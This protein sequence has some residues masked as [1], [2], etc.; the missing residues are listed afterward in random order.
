MEALLRTYFLAFMEKCFSTLEPG[1]AYQDNWHLAAMSEALRRVYSGQTKRLLINVPPRSGKSIVTT[2]AFTAWLLGHDPRRRIICVSYSEALAKSHAA[3]FRTIV[4][5]PWYRAL[6][7][8]F[9]IQPGGDRETETVTTERGYRFAVSL[10]GP[11]LGRGADLIIGDDPMSPAAALSQAVRTRELNLWMTAHRTRL[12]N[13][14]EGAIILVMQR[15]HE[16]DLV[17]HVDASEHWERLVV[18]AIAP[19]RA[20]YAVGPRAQDIYVRQQGEVLHPAREPIAV[21]DATRRAIGSLTFSAQYQ[22][23]PVPPGGNVI[24]RS[25]LRFYEAPPT[26]FDRIIA[27]WDTASTLSETSDWSV[28]MVWGAVGQDFYL[29]D[30]QRGRWETPELRRR[31]VS[32]TEDW[33]A[34]ATLIERTELGRAIAQE[35]HASGTMRP[36]LESVHLDKLARLLAV[37]A[38]FEA[39][40]VL[41]PREAPWLAAYLSEL[42]AFP[43]G[44]HDDQVDATS[45]ALRYLTP[46]QRSAAPLVRRQSVRSNPVR[47]TSAPT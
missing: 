46:R 44:A 7:P 25:W 42:L 45:Q 20:S 28:G 10:A 19:E 9:R 17:G 22:Q 2:I 4:T 24:Q 41:M 36:L 1:V 6:F 35:L 33:A 23:D 34:D 14:A 37:S 18:P 32:M 11:V 16:Q 31:I 27:S 38:R 3:A 47:R 5:S 26:T 30:V 29:L 15:L 40:Q 12:N 43:A 13:K 21:L 8:A 39:G